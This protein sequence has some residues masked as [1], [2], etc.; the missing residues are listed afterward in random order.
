MVLKRAAE[1]PLAKLRY[2]DGDGNECVESGVDWS[3]QRI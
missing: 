2:E 3:Y 1:A